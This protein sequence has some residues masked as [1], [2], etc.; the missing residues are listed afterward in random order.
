MSTTNKA[1]AL[2]NGDV[3]LATSKT[4]AAQI[5]YYK[6]FGGLNG[7]SNVDN[8]Y[9]FDASNRWSTRAPMQLPLYQPVMGTVLDT[10][11]K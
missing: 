5:V 10:I 3:I 6:M 7:T 1:C 9:T 11:L 2:R 8:V 4:S